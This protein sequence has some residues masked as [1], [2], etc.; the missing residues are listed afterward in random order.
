LNPQVEDDLLTGQS[1]PKPGRA[2]PTDREGISPTRGEE[3]PTD[4][5]R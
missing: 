2:K 1:K 3:R 4:R 5:Q